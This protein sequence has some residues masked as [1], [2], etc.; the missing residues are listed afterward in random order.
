MFVLL[1]YTALVSL[2]VIHLAGTSVE[3]VSTLEKV[4]AHLRANVKSFELNDNLDELNRWLQEVTE[5]PAGVFNFVKKS[6]VDTLTKLANL[7]LAIEGETRC[8]AGSKT[9]I[10]TTDDLISGIERKK[11]QR[12]AMICSMAKKEYQQLCAEIHSE[13][14][15]KKLNEMCKTKKNYLM[16]FTDALFV[17]AYNILEDDD[18]L[19]R[20]IQSTKDRSIINKE[21][22]RLAAEDVLNQIDLE[23]AGLEY[24]VGQPEKLDQWIRKDLIEPCKTYIQESKAVLIPHLHD[25]LVSPKDQESQEAEDDAETRSRETVIA[26]ARVNACEAAIDIMKK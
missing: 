10:D 6:L 24:S 19:D 4:E 14:V 15:E 22:V 5:K 12:I 1:K 23:N 2:I 13:V 18:D 21:I 26:M 25:A 7:R 16:L 11:I 9:I 20:I 17:I 3:G 8:D